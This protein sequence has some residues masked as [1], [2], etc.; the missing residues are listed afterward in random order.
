[1][2]HLQCISYLVGGDPTHSSSQARGPTVDGLPRSYLWAA[3]RSSRALAGLCRVDFH[4]CVNPDTPGILP[5]N[6]GG[7]LG[8]KFLHQQPSCA[9]IRQDAWEIVLAKCLKFLSKAHLSNHGKAFW[10][11]ACASLHGFEKGERRWQRKKQRGNR[12]RGRSCR[13]RN[14]PRLKVSRGNFP[15][16][17]SFLWRRVGLRFT[18]W[19]RTRCAGRTS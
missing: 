4:D 19:L 5:F 3:R 12:R 8:R 9:N 16:Q 18:T 17:L 14:C 15:C 11:D 1:M 10:V 2:M 7:N 6:V 13:A